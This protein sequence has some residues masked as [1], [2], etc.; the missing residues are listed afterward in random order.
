MAVV[1]KLLPFEIVFAKEAKNR[2]A[3]RGKLLG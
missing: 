3:C 1:K 2:L